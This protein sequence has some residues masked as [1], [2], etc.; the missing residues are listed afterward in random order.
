VFQR[1]RPEVA[2]GLGCAVAFDICRGYQQGAGNVAHRIDAHAQ[3]LELIR[4]CGANGLNG[5][6]YSPKDDDLNRA[7]WR[8]IY[9]ANRNVMKSESDLKVGMELKIP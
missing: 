4:W 1:H 9:A 3:R 7:R 5:Y 2:Q 8:D 6:A